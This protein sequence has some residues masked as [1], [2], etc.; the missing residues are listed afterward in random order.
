MVNLRSELDLGRLE[1]V[2]FEVEIYDELTPVEGR[3]IRSLNNNIPVVDI[4]VDE[5]DRDT[6]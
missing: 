4:V 6:W 5:S 2:A 1:G 3:C